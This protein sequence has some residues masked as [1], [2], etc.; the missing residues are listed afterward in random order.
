M[1]TSAGRLSSTISQ[2]S[3]RRSATRERPITRPI[4]EPSAMAI[5][6][7]TAT[8]AR[9]APRLTASAPE[10]ASS[11]IAS[12]TVS[13]SGS[14]RAPAIREPAYQA[15]ISSASE[16]S[17]AAK[18]VPRLLRGRAIERARRQLTRRPDQLG[19]ADLGQHA[20][21]RARIRLL[22]GKRPA[23]DPLAVAHPIDRKRGRVGDA[24]A[25]GEP[26]PF[27]FGAGEKLLGLQRGV[28]ETVHGRAVACAPAAV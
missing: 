13:G 12:A 21:E 9:V 1:M 14:S 17:R 26:L 23:H 11:T 10:R 25:P 15:A 20:I 19:A 6:K 22:L 2:G 16:T 8:R 5:T 27:R 24:N 4:T 3:P 7:A 28:E 18:F